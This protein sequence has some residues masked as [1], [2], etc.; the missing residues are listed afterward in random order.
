MTQPGTQG[1]PL[2]V[3][4]VTSDAA[5]AETVE[6]VC[7]AIEAA[8]MELC[9]VD[10]GRVGGEGTGALSRAIRSVLGEIAER[11]LLRGLLTSPPEV[12][13][14]FDPVSVSALTAAREHRKSLAAVVAVVPELTPRRGWV[15][16]DAD[17]YLTID[18]SAAVALSDLG[19]DGTRIIAVGPVGSRRFAEVASRDRAELRRQY[20]LKTDRV[21]IAE[22]AGMGYDGA[23]NLALQ[24][25]L[26][27]SDLT[28][29][30]DC[31]DDT[32]A[33]TALRRHV[34][35]LGMKAKLFGRTDEAPTLWRCA[36]FV[37]A[38]PSLRSVSH[39]LLVG[40]RFV[41][42]A[43]Q[44]SAEQKLA[45]AVEQRGVGAIAPTAL[46]AGAAVDA[47][48]R[49]RGNLKAYTGRNGARIIA[50]VAQ[51]VGA[52]REAVLAEVR[53]A[54]ADAARGKAEHKAA[55]RFTADARAAAEA[56]MNRAAGDLEDLGG[57]ED[58]AVPAGPGPEVGG[59]VSLEHLT[60]MQAEVSSRIAA[61]KQ[62]IWDARA[63]ADNWDKRRQQADA[64]GRNELA[65]QAA[66]A[67]DTERARM[68]VALKELA[69]LEAEAKKLEQAAVEAAVRAGAA[70]STP[71]GHAPHSGGASVDE[72]LR[73]MKRD[74][75]GAGGA[76]ASRSIDA[77]L[78]ALKKRMKKGPS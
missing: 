61:S 69:D 15:R 24:L 77:E 1:P 25:A 62:R 52:D 53:S 49:A 29:L 76:K 27:G 36:D 46:L 70:R 66:R 41:A 74:Q 21:V 23:Q 7:R 60:R 31:G 4:A 26:L 8:G 64:A 6:P 5:P 2:R 10:V 28:T 32:E 44:G 19:L 22:V 55:Q 47:A 18:D 54:V 14:G 35:G 75:G 16:T 50:D 73:R 45:E 39:A 42:L 3:L 67:A 37:I 38:R 72:L 68:H 13:I 48:G 40:A 17:R 33:A 43:P 78:D 58:N 12:T 63:A 9:L 56:R 65:E 11:R 34:P 57:D 59:G 30:F 51:I 20:R 71:A